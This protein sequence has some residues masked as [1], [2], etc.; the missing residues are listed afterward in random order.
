MQ[1]N[2]NKSI[3]KK[4]NNS[5]ALID[6]MLLTNQ[7][8]FNKLIIENSKRKEKLFIT[9]REIDLI[10]EIEKNLINLIEMCPPVKTK[11]ILSEIG[12]VYK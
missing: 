4:T 11:E 9:V 8:I 7:E 1:T 10:K 12:S 2:I 3:E 6:E 5:N